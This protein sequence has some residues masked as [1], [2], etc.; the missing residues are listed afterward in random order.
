MSKY[1]LTETDG[2]TVSKEDKYEDAETQ[3]DQCIADLTFMDMPA[4]FSI[5]K[6][7]KELI[8]VVVEA[9]VTRIKP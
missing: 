3:M 8:R 4:S 2:F 1:V 5:H 6:D 9:E 7:G